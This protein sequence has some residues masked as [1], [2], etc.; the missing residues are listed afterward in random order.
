[1]N[2]GEAVKFSM[3]ELAK[4]PKT[5]FIGYNLKHGSMAYGSLKNIS[6]E[7]IIETPVAENLMAGL[8]TGLAIEGFK[9]ILIFERHDFMLN[10]LDGLV[11]HLD[12]L[13][14]LSHG[15][16]NPDVTVRAIIGS[17]SPINPGPQHNQDFTKMFA[18]IFKMPV[19]DP[20]D[21]SEVL[22]AY[23]KA[24]TCLGSR[25]IIERRELYPVL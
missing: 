10:A 9:P 3:E 25:I 24:K 15:Q 21:S 1:M 22:E 18:G 2:Y 17:N 7:K 4:D 13:N 5:L 12:K 14:I 6:H 23:R 8:A 19:Y 16:Y 20:K 11:N